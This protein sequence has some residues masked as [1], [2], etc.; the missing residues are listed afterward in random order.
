MV[1]NYTDDPFKGAAVYIKDNYCIDIVEKPP[2]GDSKSKLNN[3]GI[4]ILSK[5]IFE[6]LYTLTPSKHGEIEFTDALRNGIKS[7]KWKIRVLKMKKNQFRG[8]FGDRDT[9]EKLKEESTWLNELLN[10]KKD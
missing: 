8:D 1:S 7:K 4:F 10:D 6:V 2:Q 3:S 5:E 9:Y